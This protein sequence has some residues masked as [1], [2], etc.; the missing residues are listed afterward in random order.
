[1]LPRSLSFPVFQLVHLLALAGIG[2]AQEARPPLA[3]ADVPL[4]HHVVRVYGR[5]HGLPS[6]W[7]V[8][9]CEDVDGYLWVATC[10]G[11]TRFDGLRFETFVRDA[12][13]GLPSNDVTALLST[14]DGTLWVGTESGVAVRERATPPG[15]RGFPDSRGLE[16]RALCE[17]PIGDVWVGARQGI[18]RARPDGTLEPVAG[19]PEDVQAICC[20]QGGV[21]WVGTDYGLFAYR[22]GRFE[23]E[24]G[25]GWYPVPALLDGSDGLVV[26]TAWGLHR[27]GDESGGVRLQGTP[28]QRVHDIAVGPDGTL[29]AAWTTHVG[30]RVDG[31]W[32]V[33][34]A[35][36]FVDC[37]HP[38]REG[39]LWVGRMNQGGLRRYA[40][41]WTGAVVTDRN[42]TCVIDD[43]DGRVWIGANEGLFRQ[44]D[45]AWEPVDA[46]TSRD[47]PSI[48]S[49]ARAS[50][51]GVWAAGGRGVVHVDADGTCTPLV[52]HPIF[53]DVSV[54]SFLEDSRGALW[55]GRRSMSSFVLDGE[56]LRPLDELG[57]FPV[58]W[59][60]EDDEGIVWAGSIDGV[61]RGTAERMEKVEDPAVPELSTRCF[62]AFRDG[63]DLWFGTRYGIVRRRDGVLRAM[64]SL[65]GL[66]SDYSERLGRDASGRLWVGGPHGVCAYAPDRIESVLA[67]TP[68]ALAPY[69]LGGHLEMTL[70]W[71][72]YS[73][74]KA[75]RAA[76]GV[77]YVCGPKGVLTVPPGPRPV[78]RVEPLVRVE[79]AFV[80]GEPVEWADV[81]RLPSGPRRLSIRFSAPTFDAPEDVSARY[82][83]AGYDSGWTLAGLGRTAVY[84]GL[85]PGRYT[86]EIQAARGGDDDPAPPFAMEIEVV[87]RLWE[88]PGV[89][90]AVPTLILLL[91]AF[92]LDRRSRRIRRHNAALEREV[93]ERRRA[94]EVAGQR[95]EE[96][97]RVSR[98]ASLGE[99][100]TSIAHEVKQPLFAI[101]SNAQTARELL[102]R[103][104]RDEDEVRE[105]LEDIA[106]DG[107]RAAAIIDHIRGLVQK[108]HQPLERLDLNE[109][110]GEVTRLVGPEADR[111]GVALHHDLAPAL[112]AVEGDPVELQQVLINL[113][114]N[115]IQAMD[116]RRNGA[117][118]VLL[119]TSSSNGS[120]RVDV[121]DHGVGIDADRAKRMFEPFFTTKPQGTGMGLA[122]NRA[123]VER[124]RGTI[125]V[126]SSPGVGSTFTIELGAVAGPDA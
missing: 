122:V 27:H 47:E 98:A 105:A 124:H 24:L 26:G 123:I 91:L 116:E 101:V 28:S 17:G 85:R 108:E 48:R 75:W 71:G 118:E 9:V 10:N 70:G 88:R 53:E 43:E 1:M 8:D 33:H 36:G 40:P 61:Y 89:Q 86:L 64:T 57:T 82:R 125:S 50:T 95:W 20:D 3:Q 14:S 19:A 106:S 23:R 7:I 94:Q 41:T 74:P 83:L 79:G 66:R 121:K 11:L 111:R 6:E 93:A 45:G 102:G 38:D 110:I 59:F 107:Q 12:E 32:V 72:G 4:E 81:L 2:L 77:L 103:E 29:F 37:I 96:L 73:G 97:V 39:S 44:V 65:D 34:H 31:D 55:V 120:V 15:F 13:G 114:L 112:P 109:I 104:P 51:G 92:S 25:D 63:A 117:A 113:V 54:Q 60:L 16:V 67:G 46:I 62:A 76:D 90:I 126:D 5:E 99:L 56:V 119:R 49:L 35:G 78:R 21:L 69:E 52:P 87:P 22:S 42:T 58:E 30:V 80:D 68:T 115:G 84:T 100:T 18:W